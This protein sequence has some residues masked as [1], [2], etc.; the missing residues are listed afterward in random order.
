MPSIQMSKLEAT[1]TSGQ[2]TVKRTS[3]QSESQ[4]GQAAWLSMAFLTSINSHGGS[5]DGVCTLEYVVIWHKQPAGPG[6]KNQGLKIKK[7]K[8]QTISLHE[9]EKTSDNLCGLG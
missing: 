3:S 7:L 9:H 1:E 8:I 2:M 6:F 5:H 4:H